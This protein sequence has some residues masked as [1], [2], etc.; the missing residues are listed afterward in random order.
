VRCNNM[1]M[2]EIRNCEPGLNSFA[3]VGNMGTT[4]PHERDVKPI[5]SSPNYHSFV[6]VFDFAPG[7]WWHSV[8]SQN[9]V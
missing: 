4:A 5:F 3:A 1:S 6:Y 2:L 7:L 8:N 9:S